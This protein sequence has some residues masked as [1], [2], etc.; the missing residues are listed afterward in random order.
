MQK[1]KCLD[2]ICLNVLAPYDRK[3]IRKKFDSL[4]YVRPDFKVLKKKEFKEGV[5]EK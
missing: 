4:R 5:F 3:I 2:L 1:N